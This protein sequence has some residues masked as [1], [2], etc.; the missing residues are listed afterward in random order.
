[1]S[2]FNNNLSYI[3][4]QKGISQKELANKIGVDQS[5]ISLWE[6]GMDTTIV[7]ALKLA[8][9]LNVPYPEFL[10]KDLR[11]EENTV[12]DNSHKL[13]MI[14]T[15]KSKNLSDDD[16]KMII[17]IMDNLNNRNKGSDK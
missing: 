9:A 2:Y 1:M 6:K 7:N 5:T 15:D 11:V 17:G 4:K 16:K 3:R 12:L 13:D 10:G 14:I 8:D